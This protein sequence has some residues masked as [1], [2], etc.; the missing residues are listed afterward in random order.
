MGLVPDALEEVE[1]LTGAG[2]DHRVVV[3][4]QPHL[5]EALGQTADGDVVDAQLVQGPLGGRD[6]GL[7]SVDDDELRGVGEALGPSVVLAGLLPVGDGG[8]GG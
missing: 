4:G 8:T 2:Q 5:F 3:I 1:A 6:L 7:P